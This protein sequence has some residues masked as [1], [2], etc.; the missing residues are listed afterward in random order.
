[1][2]PFKWEIVSLHKNV[3]LNSSIKMIILNNFYIFNI[4]NTVLQLLS[5]PSL[6]EV[7]FLAL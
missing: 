7:S 5:K 2:K 4:L 1:M 3:S 6:V